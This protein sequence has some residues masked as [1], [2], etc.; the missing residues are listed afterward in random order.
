[1]KSRCPWKYSAQDGLILIENLE[2]EQKISIDKQN[3][4]ESCGLV[5]NALALID[6][7][8]RKYQ[9]QIDSNVLPGGNTFEDSISSANQFSECTVDGNM[10]VWVDY[11]KAVDDKTD[12]MQ[13]DPQDF[14]IVI[15]NHSDDFIRLKPHQIPD[16]VFICMSMIK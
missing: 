6:S 8:V 9:I 15:D 11:R 12:A 1:M 2:K 3:V 16:F 7:C 14:R 5:L 4:L 13:P 10:S